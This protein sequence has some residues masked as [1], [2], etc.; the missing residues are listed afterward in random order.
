MAVTQAVSRTYRGLR[1]DQRRDDRR[2]RLMDAALD[3]M[4]TQGWAATSVRGVCE[5]ARVGPRF[6]YESFNDLEALAVAVH[7][8]IFERAISRA[9]AANDAAGGSL[10]E[11]VHAGISAI[12]TDLTDDP[13]R[14]RVAFAEAH[15][16]ETLMRRRFD[17]MRAIADVVAS[18]A[19]AVIDVPPGSDS[20][21]QGFALLFT[22]GIAE[23]M[24]VWLDGGLDITREQL[25]EMCSAFLLSAAEN[26][27]ATADRLRSTAD[28]H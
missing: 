11:K 26:L 25:I 4:G 14:A 17:S 27:P 21:V 12:I 7:D 22:G 16:S 13:R 2:R 15:G 1:A 3:I 8:E 6:F 28:L 10:A 5:Q 23:M 9:L 24:L 18:E 19:H 20:V